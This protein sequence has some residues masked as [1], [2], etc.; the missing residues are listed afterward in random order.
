MAIDVGCELKRVLRDD[1][2]YFLN[3]GDKFQDKDLQ[4]VPFRVAVEMQKQGWMLRNIIVWHKPNHMPT[5]IKDRLNTVWEPIFFFVKGTGKYYAP[6]YYV[7]INSIRVPH[8]GK[9]PDTTLPHTLSESE[10]RANQK[11]LI[12]GNN[13]NGKYRN[14]ENNRGA[15]PGA[16]KSLYGEYYSKQRKHSISKSNKIEIITYLRERR[17]ELGVRV[18]DI[19]KKLGY[20]AKAGHWFRLD[21]GGSLPTH[22]DWPRVKKIL[23]LDDRYDDIMTEMHY[24][25]QTVKKHPEGKNPGDV[26]SINLDRITDAHFSIFPIELPRRIISAFCPDDGI[27]LDPFAGSGTTGIAA[28]ELGRR[29]I[30]IELNSDYVEIIRKRVRSAKRTLDSFSSHQ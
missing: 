29:S 2:S 15:S 20:K 3:I 13:Y 11:R 12:N 9:E 16:R 7:D 5:P 19:D 17:K 14:H 8:K 18:E 26:W 30:L 28:M 25:L 6:D 10:Y 23:K 1:G 22:E 21:P 4:M 27:V 24:V